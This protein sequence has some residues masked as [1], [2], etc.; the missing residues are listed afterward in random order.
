LK[1][2]ICSER[3]NS[4]SARRP[5]AYSVSTFRLLARTFPTSSAQEPKPL[6]DA[7]RAELIRATLTTGTFNLLSKTESHF[8]LS[9]AFSVRSGSHECEAV[10]PRNLS[11]LS[12]PRKRCQPVGSTGFPPVINSSGSF[13][14]AGVASMQLVAGELFTRARKRSSVRSNQRRPKRKM[15]Q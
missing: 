9:G 12:R 10:R 3:T 14:S 4:P 5:T 13:L 2:E 7:C 8:R 11:N 15:I 6:P 1:P